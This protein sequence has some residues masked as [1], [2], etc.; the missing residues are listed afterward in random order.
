MERPNLLLL[1][2]LR[3]VAPDGPRAVTGHAGRLLVELAVAGPVVTRER[4]ADAR[5]GDEPPPSG[6]APLRYRDEIFT[7]VT[8]T[9]AVP[10]GSAVTQ[11]GQ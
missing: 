7:G 2:P 4:L 8:V 10:Y 5:G 11:T 1:G 3:V 9:S 6:D